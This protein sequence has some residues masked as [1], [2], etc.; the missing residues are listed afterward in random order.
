[1][2]IFSNFFSNFSHIARETGIAFGVERM[3]KAVDSAVEQGGSEILKKAMVR[4]TADHRAM[5]LSKIRGLDDGVAIDNLMARYEE[6]LRGKAGA[7]DWWVNTMTRLMLA[8][9]GHPEEFDRALKDLGHMSPSEFYQA[10]TFLDNDVVA[11]WFKKARQI[12][13][14]V[15]GSAWNGTKTAARNADNKLEPVADALEQ[16][17]ERRRRTRYR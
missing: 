12:A 13:G 2:S 1:M 6:S 14:E 15:I 11:Q 4:I 5:L 8:L 9:E 17:Q 10:L 16:F 7:E 3:M